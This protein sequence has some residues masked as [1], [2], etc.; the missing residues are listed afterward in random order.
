MTR[1]CACA[2]LSTDVHDDCNSRVGTF[3]SVH[4]PQYKKLINKVLSLAMKYMTIVSTP[5]VVA[6]YPS[7]VVG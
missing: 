3:T 7:P 5:Q 6:N 1:L 2:A 4:E